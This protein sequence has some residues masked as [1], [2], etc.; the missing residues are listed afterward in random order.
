M[1]EKIFIS[2]NHNDDVLVDTIARRLELE[3]GRNNIFY[4]AWSIQPGDSIIGKMDEGL[5]SFS[6]FFFFVSNNSLNSKMVT[7]EW[8]TAL[9]IATNNG[10]KFVAV[11]IENCSIPLIISDKLYIDLYGKGLDSAVAEMKCI[12]KS[13]NTYVPL[14]EVENLKVSYKQ[15]DCNKVRITVRANLYAEINPT[16]AFACSNRF[17]DFSTCFNISDGVTVSNKGS[18]ITDTD[19]TLNMRTV[20][21]QRPLRP[22]FP[23]VFEVTLTG[24]NQLNDVAVYILKNAETGE[25]NQL[26]VEH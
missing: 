14:E 22:G 17:E 23:F 2:Y 19:L 21:L 10:L 13:E 18:M 7:L 24:V 20:Q 6:T 8:Q 9:N 5:S 3:F 11:R 25:F 1:T 16:L 15:I 12:V 26:P 4:D